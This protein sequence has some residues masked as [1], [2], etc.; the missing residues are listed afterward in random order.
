MRNTLTVT[1]RSEQENDPEYKNFIFILQCKSYLKTIVFGKTEILG[2]KYSS[3]AV[4]ELMEMKMGEYI[5]ESLEKCLPN[6]V[7]NPKL[8]KNMNLGNPV[9]VNRETARSAMTP[10]L[11]D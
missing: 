3:Q 4:Q 9:I 8:K 6:L 2:I 5:Q 1:T 7:K 10:F 11:I